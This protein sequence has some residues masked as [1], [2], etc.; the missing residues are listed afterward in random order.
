MATVRCS[1]CPSVVV[2]LRPLGARGGGR[3]SLLQYLAHALRTARGQ[4]RAPWWHL[5]DHRGGCRLSSLRV[6][7][8]P[9]LAAVA[10]LSGSWFWPSSEGASVGFGVRLSR[11][12]SCSGVAKVSCGF[13]HRV[14]CSS[15]IRVRARNGP[16]DNRLFRGGRHRL[17]IIG[18]PR[19]VSSFGCRRIDT[20]SACGYR[21]WFGLFGERVRS[22]LRVAICSVG[23]GKRL[24]YRGVFGCPLGPKPTPFT[25]QIDPAFGQGFRRVAI[26]VP[27]SAGR[28]CA[29]C[30]A[31]CTP[32]GQRGSGIR[33]QGSR[34]QLER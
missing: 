30:S 14:S 23:S 34:Q 31:C 33:S 32:R 11:H 26:V 16:V 15:G 1:R 20:G 21:T 18:V 3:R 28:T 4:V 10:G 25:D 27:G 6:S 7:E 22:V 19:F 9:L 8:G 12:V 5:D 2:S 29:A 13:G 24:A 17:G